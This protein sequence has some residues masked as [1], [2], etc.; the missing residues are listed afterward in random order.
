MTRREKMERR[1]ERRREWAQGRKEKADA[2]FS[3]ASGIADNIPFGQ[4]ILIGHHSEKRARKDQ[5]RIQSAMRRGMDN[6]KMAGNHEQRADGIQRQ[7]DRS[8]FSDD[9]DAVG[10]L[11][12]RVRLI[13]AEIERCKYI[14]REIRKGPG[15]QGRIDPKMTEDEAAALERNARFAGTTGFPS[16]QL[17]NMG[18]N[19]RRLEKR[20]VEV[21]AR[22]ERQERAEAAGGV[23]ISRNPDANWCTVVFAEKPARE[24]LDAL[25]SAGYGWGGGCWNGYLDRL[26]K[27]VSDLVTGPEGR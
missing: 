12:E 25:R 17:S 18:A 5:E 15:W 14:N 21:K 24:I 20:I 27:I 23:Q 22:E 7:L 4:P 9:P 6:E 2:A 11:T 16:Y 19:A 1:M 3:Q 10:A 26:P 13:R 8:I